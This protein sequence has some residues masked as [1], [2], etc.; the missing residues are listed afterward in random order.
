LV[1]AAGPAKDE[2][3]FM[4][5][6]PA[7]LALA[8]FELALLLVGTGLFLRLVLSPAQRSQYLAPRNLPPWPVTLAE[9]VIFVVLMFAC[10]L[11]VQMGLQLLLRK[12][13]EHAI[14]HD[15][16]QLCLNGFGFDGGGLI[17]WLLFPAMRKNWYA[18]YE[19][20]SAPGP[21]LPRRS[22]AKSGLAAAF[23]LVA[24][25]PLLMVSNLGWTFVLDKLGL[26]EEPQNLIAIFADTKS[27]IV[28]T[29]MLVVACVLAPIYEELLFRGGLYRFCREK[30]SRTAALLLS[31]CLFGLAHLNWASFLPLAILGMVLALAYEAT[32]DIRVPIIAHGLFNLNTVLL[33]LSGLA[34]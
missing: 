29:A 11:T 19:A 13:V 24:V 7:Q 23:T 25:L 12:V 22:W 18:G 21:A 20:T 9:F 10:G 4:P 6:S 15:G 3:S 27:P 8:L 1:F 2:V 34:K 5:T 33:V 30:M 16:L 17:G 32:G 28:I 14:D 26:P 31:G